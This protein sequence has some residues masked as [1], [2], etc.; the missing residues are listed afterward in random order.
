MRKASGGTVELARLMLGGCCTGVTFFLT[1]R[2][3]ADEGATNAAAVGYLLPVV[4]VA[5]GAVVLNEELSVRIVAGM[6][7]VLAGL[8]LTRWRRR[9]PAG[10]TAGTAGTAGTATVVVA[11]G[12]EPVGGQGQLR[13]TKSAI[14]GAIS[15]SRSS[16]A[17]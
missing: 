9:P 14:S 7:V 1:F 13:S 4:S 2:I 6:A 3:I 16:R 17:K 10:V 5:L 12:D 15:G 11:A 8:A